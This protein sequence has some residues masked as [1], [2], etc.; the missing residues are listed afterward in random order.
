[1]VIVAF[2]EIFLKCFSSKSI[3]LTAFDMGERADSIGGSVLDVGDITAGGLGVSAQ[4]SH[5]APS[6]SCC[7]FESSYRSSFEVASVYHASHTSVGTSPTLFTSITSYHF[8]WFEHK[9][10]Y[11]KWFALI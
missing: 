10:S 4:M 5:F 8:K 2:G 6:S 9:W 7:S 11:L 3:D 1:M